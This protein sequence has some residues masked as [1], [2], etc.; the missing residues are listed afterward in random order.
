VK[1]KLL[2]FGAALLALALRLLNIAQKNMWFD[3]V[4]SW[5]LSQKTIKEIFIGSAGD[6]HP[7]LFYILLKYWTYL[8]S[9]T[10]FSMRLLS[11]LLGM[12]SLIFIYK[13]AR[14]VLKSDYEILFVFILYAL[15]PLN[16]YYSQEVRMLNLNL[17][18]CLGSVYYFLKYMD[19]QTYKNGLPYLAFSMLAA[20]T[21]YFAFLIIFTE[22][23]IVFYN[24]FKNKDKQLLKRYPVYLIAIMIMYVP[25][26]PVM[27][28][29]VSKGQPWRTEQT[30]AM[31]A[32]NSFEY[33]KEAFFS[34]YI[35]YETLVWVYI[36]LAG[37]M[38]IIFYLC[39]MAIRL[40]GAGTERTPEQRNLFCIVLLFF[41]PLLA[42]IAISIKSSI[43]LSRYL[44]IIVPYLLI[45]L[46]GLTL[47]FYKKKT[48][49]ILLGVIILI[50]GIGA[51]IHYENGFKNNDYRKIVSYIEQ[52]YNGKDMIIVEPHY[53][54]WSIEYYVK[55]NNTSLS[56]PV[57]MGWNF[58]GILDSLN[59]KKDYGNFWI[60]LDYSSMDTV[61]YKELPSVMNSLGYKQES[62][63]RFYIIPNK[64]SVQRYVK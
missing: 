38:L 58:N 12:F 10:V 11:V 50:S 56:Q 31:V 20:Y 40:T 5:H 52:G 63:K 4:Y 46:T 51:K 32:K 7:P 8:F 3:E 61:R 30:A 59:I 25:W 44:S 17:F 27:L 19:K 37:T 6:I 34:Y 14:R 54:A 41:I 21:H 64:V 29:Q 2:L 28:S 47:L 33:F 57:N 35:Y 1:T 16:I 24:Y 13:I 49:V 18:L 15:S 45:S 26:I 39:F 48:A 62:E 36:S 9:D 42:G 53:M 55:H 60:V 43:L 23:F 22:V